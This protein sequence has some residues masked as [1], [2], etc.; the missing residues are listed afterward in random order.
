[1]GVKISFGEPAKDQFRWR[2]Y[3]QKLVKGSDH[4]RSYFKCSTKTC[5]A[6]KYHEKLDETTVEDDPPVARFRTIYLGTHVH[7]VVEKLKSVVSSSEEFISRVSDNFGAVQHAPPTSP[8]AVVAEIMEMTDPSSEHDPEPSTRKNARQTA[9][10]KRVSAA[11]SEPTNKLILL[12]PK[13]VDPNADGFPWRKYGRKSIKG[14]DIPREY[15]RCSRVDCPVK[16]QVE[17]HNDGAHSVTYEYCHNHDISSEFLERKAGTARS[18]SVA[19]HPKVVP[20]LSPPSTRRKRKA[21]DSGSH[22]AEEPAPKLLK[23]VSGVV[24]GSAASLDIDTRANPAS[25]LSR[26]ALSALSPLFSNSDVAAALRQFD[27][28]AGV[29][30]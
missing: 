15:F 25:T 23:S 14:S 12:V 11:S 19:A 3:G 5:T 9:S 4:P 29:I 1:M 10:K 27:E 30:S 13:H 28:Y 6:K 22:Q 21:P 2:K 18:K 7:P 16:K 24:S 8:G 26:N 20:P 17:P